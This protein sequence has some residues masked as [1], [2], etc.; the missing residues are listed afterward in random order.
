MTRLHGWLAVTEPDPQARY[1]VM[2]GWVPDHVIR[3]AADV[4]AEGGADRIFT[5]GVPVDQGAQ[6]SKFGGTYAEVAAVMLADAG[7][8]PNLICPVPAAAVKRDRTRAMAAALRDVL[9]GEPVPAAGKRI[10]LLTLD[11]HARRS[12]AIFQEELG[13]EWTVGVVSA[14][15]LDYDPVRWYTQSA[16]AKA[17]LDEVIALTIL[18]FGGN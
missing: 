3:I 8:G 17:V 11:T 10:N 18:F 7:V 2:E 12:R 9:A 15:T 16:G 13:P 6:I 14:P 4:A 5:T 1:L